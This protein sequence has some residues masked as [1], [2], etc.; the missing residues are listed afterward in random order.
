MGKEFVKRIYRELG[1]RDEEP[2]KKENGEDRREVKE[3]EVEELGKEGKMYDGENGRKGKGMMEREGVWE[4]NAKERRENG[5][6]RE[7]KD[8]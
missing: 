5:R 7:R 1:R 2:R 3:E 6:R 8:G 4:K